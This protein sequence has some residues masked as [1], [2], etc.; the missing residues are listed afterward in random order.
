MLT[1]AIVLGQFN[2][3]HDVWLL[4]ITKYVNCRLFKIYMRF[5]YWNSITRG[6]IFEDDTKKT[7]VGGGVVGDGAPR[8][9]RKLLDASTDVA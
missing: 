3:L 1:N 9:G 4:D 8:D 7:G 6:V 2:E 5:I